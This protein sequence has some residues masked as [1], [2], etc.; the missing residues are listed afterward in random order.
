MGQ[1]FEEVK[2]QTVEGLP[3]FEVFLTTMTAKPVMNRFAA[4]ETVGFFSKGMTMHG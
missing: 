3:R 4:V 2:K 1:I